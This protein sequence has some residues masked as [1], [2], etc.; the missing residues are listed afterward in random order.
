MTT[1]KA[2]ILHKKSKVL[3]LLIAEKDQKRVELCSITESVQ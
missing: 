2:F 1:K 3:R